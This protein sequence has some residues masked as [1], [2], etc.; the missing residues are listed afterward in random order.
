MRELTT[1]A[2]FEAVRGWIEIE[3]PTQDAAAVNRMADHAE[4]L[5]RGVGARVER[6]Q[7]REGFGDVLIGRVPGIEQGPGILVLG[8]LD[9]V[10]PLGTLD[11]PLP[12]RIEGDRAYGPGIYDMKGSN[13]M[14]LAALAH[15]AATGRRPRRDVTVMLVPD[16]EMGSPTSRAGIEAEARAHAIVLVAEPSG[17]GGRLTVGRHGIARYHLRTR[18]IPAH[19]GAYH[20]KR[21]SAIR[22][23][24]RQVLA[25]EAMTDHAR[26][27]T[28]NVGTIAGGT[29]ENMV[30]LY[31]EAC[32]YCLV[33]TPEDE[34][35]VRTALAALRPHDPDVTLAM[36]PGLSRPAYAK[37]PAIQAL[38]D[39][40]VRLGRDL[41]FE[42][43][44]ERVAGGGSDGNFTGALGIP[45]LDGLGVIG[46]GPHTH[47]EHLLLSCL[48]PRTR[49]WVRLF[50]TLGPNVL[51]G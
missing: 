30:P 34:R 17:E 39:H 22:E 31:C 38:Y 48:V 29:H 40:A 51:P 5:L 8:H 46:D 14:A 33:P 45:T 26:N 47:A 27:V 21:R 15:L 7:G 11:G 23:M 2:L 25:V 10:H 18:G 16:E 43:P 44:G 37:T 4:A 24:A 35:A 20:A 42:I 12:I 9:T 36:T 6:R 13:A 19:A 1:E 32:V 49:L 3:S 41:G 28:L 50:E